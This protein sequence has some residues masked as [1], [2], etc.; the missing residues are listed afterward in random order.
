M[1]ADPLSPKPPSTYGEV[2]E[3]T[4]NCSRDRTFQS[5]SP[6]TSRQPCNTLCRDEDGETSIISILDWGQICD[7]LVILKRSDIS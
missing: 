6:H 1:S 3:L 4:A 5:Q 2:K 7:L